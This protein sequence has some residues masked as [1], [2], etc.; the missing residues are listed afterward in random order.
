MTQ[1]TLP[2][3][4]AIPQVPAHRLFLAVKPDADAA[5]RIAQRVALLRPDVGFKARPLRVERL[6]VTLHHLGD[7]VELPDTLVARACEAAAGVALPPFEVIFDQV[8]SFHG[9]RDHRPFVLTGGVGLHALIDF[10]HALGAALERAGLRVPQ[11]RFVPHVT[12]L[13]DRGGFAPKPVE[14]ISWTV[15]EFVL[16]DS[17]LGRTRYDEKGRWS[18]REGGLSS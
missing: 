8:V 18:L 5:R 2:G 7:F 13:Y 14:P 15:R 16:I 4:E 6:H 9:R 1:L 17:W 11:A 10:Q 3:F 12:L